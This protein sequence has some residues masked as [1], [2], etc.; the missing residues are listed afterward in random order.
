VFRASFERP[1]RLSL[2]CGPEVQPF[3]QEDHTRVGPAAGLGLLLL[4]SSVLSRYLFPS[5]LRPIHLSHGSLPI[6][7]NLCDGQI[8]VAELPLSK[9][10]DTRRRTTSPVAT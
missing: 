9:V 6:D 1:P 3:R 5:V 2:P 4:F 7:G 10:R 8:N